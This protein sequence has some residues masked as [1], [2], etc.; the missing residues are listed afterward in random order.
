MLKQVI[1]SLSVIML[2]MTIFAFTSNLFAETSLNFDL[3]PMHYGLLN[4]EPL[5]QNENKGYTY[6]YVANY[7][8]K[9]DKQLILDKA[10]D[11]HPSEL[12]I[13]VSTASTYHV[14]QVK[15]VR[16][17]AVLL[18]NPLEADVAEGD[19]VWNFYNDAL[20][21]NSF[22]FKA[23]V[24]YAMN[25]LKAENFANKIHGF[26]GDSW[27]DNDSVVPYFET[28]LNASRIINRGVGGRKAIDVLNAFDTDFP[29]NASVQPDYI[30]VIL[31]TNDYWNEVS[32]QSYL[33]NMTK[34]IRK[35]NNLGAKA[36]VFTPSVG[37]FVSD[38]NTDRS[39]YYDLSNNYADDLLKLH[40]AN[41]SESIKAYTQNNDLVIE[42]TEPQAP[43][44]GFH[45]L[46]L[47]DTDNNPNTGYKSDYSRWGNT[48]SDYLVSDGDL[49]KSLTNNSNWVWR[50]T[51]TTVPA[52]SNKITV[53]KYDIGLGA[54]GQNTSLKVA[55]LVMSNDW[56]TVE[57]YYPKS[58]K[59][60]EVVINKPVTRQ[61]NAVKDVAISNGSAV[62][63]D[64]LANDTGSGLSLGWIDTPNNGSVEVLNNKLVYTPNPGFSGEEDFWYELKDATGNNAWGNI[65]ITVNS[66]G[67]GNG[68]VLQVNNDIVS[69]P[70][71]GSV[72]IDV[73]S[74]DIG[75]NLVLDDFD[76][77]WSGSASIVGN[78]LLYQSDGNFIGELVTW[79]GV[80]DANNDTA[81]AKLTVN[82]VR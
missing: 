10:W 33:D 50:D 27:F 76:S 53:N 19:N 11:L 16:G 14:A 44:T 55:V 63:I 17:D 7:A 78:K 82:I 6:F 38:P 61:L 45:Y 9:G 39:F 47:I 31:G 12:I 8:N 20:H 13:Y 34:I 56:N 58:G 2:T 75:N 77:V 62:N 42:L 66:S 80:I 67:G 74:N 46:Y 21:P 51:N 29:V 24:E 59:M 52:T 65:I 26:A 36:I 70:L 81:W 64:I 18:M 40:K 79:Y 68:S 3:V 5:T 73:L 28:K 48:G 25:Y 23:I 54:S 4:D 30:W 15:E 35:I 32:R 22:G 37:P 69:V 57:D 43:N 71:G 60:Q 72:L 49:Y 1:H 41:S